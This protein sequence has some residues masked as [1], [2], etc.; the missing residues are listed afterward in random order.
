[1][2]KIITKKNDKNIW[3]LIILIFFTLL[4]PM[5]ITWIFYGEINLSMKNWL[6]AVN[7]KNWGELIDGTIGF[8]KSPVLLCSWQPFVICTGILLFVLTIWLILTY[9]K[10]SRINYLVYI[11]ST[12]FMLFLI[13]T[14]GLLPYN[15][16]WTIPVRIIIVIVGYFSCFLVLNILINKIIIKTKFASILA[17]E[18]IEQE[19][20]TSKYINDEIKLKKQKEKEIVEIDEKDI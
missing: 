5:I 15:Q 2:N 9:F 1:M 7:G 8:G 6:V 19:M 11:F 18:F 13:M 14:T 4:I 17:N 12:W 16:S 20:E 3:I 10:L